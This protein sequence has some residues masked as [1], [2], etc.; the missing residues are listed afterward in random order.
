MHDIKMW[1]NMNHNLDI[2][3]GFSVMVKHE[4]WHREDC[5]EE[6]SV[7][8]IPHMTIERTAR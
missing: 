8:Q 4:L 2:W 5:T 1:K 7:V 6:L 3:F